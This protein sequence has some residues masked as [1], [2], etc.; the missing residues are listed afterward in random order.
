MKVLFNFAHNKFY[1]AQEKCA[2]TGLGI[3]GFDKAFKYRMSD[4]DPIF[5]N[6]NKHI[7]TQSRGGGYWLWKYYFADKLL[8]D[9]TIPENSYIF[10]CDSG[11]HFVESI[12]KMI[13]VMEKHNENIITFRQTHSA[14]VWTK[15]DAFII[16]NAD[17]PKYTQT[18]QRVGGFFLFKKNNFSRKFFRECLF[19]GQDYR[20]ITDAP[21]QLGEPNYAGFIDHRHDESLISIM[22]K[23]YDLFPYRNPCQFGFENDVNFTDSKYSQEAYDEMIQKYG[24]MDTWPQKYGCYFHGK[25]IKQYPEITVDDRSTYPTIINLTRDAK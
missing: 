2:E 17:E 18:G 7:L 14:Y 3:G 24:D 6:K 10:Y 21:N 12:D 1:N 11:A 16:M 19:Y 4:I 20:V 5:Y 25:S 8:N 23:K 22:A 15:R 9:N 13:E